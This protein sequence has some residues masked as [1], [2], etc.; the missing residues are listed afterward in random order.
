MKHN[1]NSIKTLSKVNIKDLSSESLKVFDSDLSENID[2][3]ENNI[4]L[5]LAKQVVG[6]ANASNIECS[7]LQTENKTVAMVSFYGNHELHQRHGISKKKKGDI[8]NIFVGNIIALMRCYENNK[9][10][11]TFTWK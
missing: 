4:L 8:N 9:T 6:T 1:Y 11:R 7:Y 10:T 3:M 2:I 5:L